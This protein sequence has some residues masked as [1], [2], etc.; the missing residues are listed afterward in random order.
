MSERLYDYIGITDL[1]DMLNKILAENC[2]Q[3]IEKIKKDTYKN[4]ILP[5]IS[6]LTAY[7]DNYMY[8]DETEKLHANH[9][10]LWGTLKRIC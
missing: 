7:Q 3:P 10:G 8:F 6:A 2:S 5:F 9:W 1:K 4:I